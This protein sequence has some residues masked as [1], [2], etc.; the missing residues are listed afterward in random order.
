MDAE[1]RCESR[2]AAGAT[3]APVP[4][5]LVRHAHA[6]DRRTWRGPDRDRPLTPRGWRQ[7]DALVAQLAGYP[8]ARILSSSYLRCRQTVERLAVARGLEVEGHSDL[9]DDAE[10]AQALALL[11]ELAGAPAVLCSHGDLMVELLAALATIDGL[12]LTPEHPCAKGSTWVLRGNGRRFIQ[13]TY[14]PPAG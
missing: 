7:A 2:Q 13:A 10:T 3:L 12:P 11:R 8:V 4:L 1:P 6:G 5:L 9:G 14:L